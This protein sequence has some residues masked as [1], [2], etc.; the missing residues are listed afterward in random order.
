MGH[1]ASTQ[2]KQ[3]KAPKCIMRL[4]E[5]KKPGLKVRGGRFKLYN[6]VNQVTSAR[7][8]F[9]CKVRKRIGVT[10]GMDSGAVLPGCESQL[11]HLL[12]CDLGHFT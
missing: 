4:L 8:L 5:Q 1:T 7:D 9:I 12:L 11:C 2:S 6:L 3:I 10:L